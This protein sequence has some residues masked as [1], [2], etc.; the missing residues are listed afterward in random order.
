MQQDK[1]AERQEFKV[2]NTTEKKDYNKL[3]IEDVLKRMDQSDEENDED[4]SQEEQADQRK[5]NGRLDLET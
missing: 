3:S 2:V 5:D 1:E 4:E